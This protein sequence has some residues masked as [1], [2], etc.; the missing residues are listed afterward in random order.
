MWAGPTLSLWLV[1]WCVLAGGTRQKKIKK[2]ALEA[3]LPGP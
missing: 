2:A 1:A 3:A